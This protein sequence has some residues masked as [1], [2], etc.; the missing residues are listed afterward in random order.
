MSENLQSNT[1]SYKIILIGSSAI[2]KTSLCNRIQKKEFNSEMPITIGVDFMTLE[3]TDYDTF[4]QLRNIYNIQLWDTAGHEKFS[5][6]TKT[7][8]RNSNVVLLCF[9]LTS[10]TSFIELDKWMIDIKSIIDQPY[11]ICLMGLKSDL[12]SVITDEEITEFLNKYLITT[13]HRYS[14]KKTINTKTIEAILINAVKKYDLLIEDMTYAREL[15]T[16]KFKL[17]NAIINPLIS[18]EDTRLD[19]IKYCC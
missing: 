11:Y 7:Y 9:D 4:T 8:Y 1:K 15:S 3:L 19:N 16:S 12:D 10:R 2:G 18:A 5:A 14:S 6:I 17:D 13:Y